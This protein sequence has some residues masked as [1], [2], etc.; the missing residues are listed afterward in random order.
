MNNTPLLVIA[1][2]TAAGKS[3]LAIKIA[4]KIGAEIISCNSAQVYKYMDI[5][6]AKPTPEEREQVKHHLM[7]YVMPDEDYSAVRYKNDCDRAIEEILSKNKIPIICGGTGM[8]LSAVL[9]QMDFGNTDKSEK[10]REEL[11]Q[12]EKTRGRQYLYSML[13]ELDSE[14]AQR[15]HPNDVKRVIRAIEICRLGGKNKRGG[16]KK[17]RYAHYTAILNADRKVLYDRINKRVDRMIENGLL[18]E[19]KELTDSGYGGCKSLHAIGYKE[20]L[21]YFGGQMTLTEA[22]EKIKQHTR[23]FAKRQLTWF[24]GMDGAVWYDINKGEDDLAEDVI[25]NYNELRSI[26]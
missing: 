4:K 17:H 12:L 1:G 8:Y 23:N 7:D 9:Y 22:I 14:A 5:G 2:P 3:G 18:D 20:L 21:M 6:T 13:E 15:L 11:A 16:E 25:K 24:K 26:L 10:L 19:V